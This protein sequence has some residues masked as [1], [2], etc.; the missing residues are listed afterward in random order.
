MAEGAVEVLVEDG[1]ARL[2]R[3][4]QTFDDLVRGEVIPAR[5]LESRL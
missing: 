3:R 4:R 1:Q 5:K 2:I